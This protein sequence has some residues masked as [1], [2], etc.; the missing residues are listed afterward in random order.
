MT[1]CAAPVLS[2]VLAGHME[3]AQGEL[4]LL[5]TRALLEAGTFRLE[6]GRSRVA[7]GRSERSSTFLWTAAVRPDS[8]P[9]D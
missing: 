4:T 8:E 6:S 7:P 3:W 2:T 5:A 9:S 1:T